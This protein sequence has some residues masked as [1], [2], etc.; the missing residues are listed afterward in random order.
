MTNKE[1]HVLTFWHQKLWDCNQ[2]EARY[3]SAGEVARHVGQSTETAKKY[4]RRLV[5]EG[6]A[7]TAKRQ[8]PNKLKYDVYHVKLEEQLS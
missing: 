6:G 5:K 3:V 2:A 4:L 8:H 1:A 7:V